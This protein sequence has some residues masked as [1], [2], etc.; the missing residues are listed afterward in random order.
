VAEA[1][2]PAKLWHTRERSGISLDREQRWWHDGEPVEHP[3]IIEAFNKGLKV[4]DDG[5]YKLEFGDDWCFVEVQGAAYR[6]LVLDEAEGDRLSI[7]L[8]D[9]TAEWLDVGS[10]V[11]DADGVLTAAVKGGRARARFSREAQFAL[12]ERVVSEGGAALVRIGGRSVPL[13]QAAWPLDT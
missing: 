9:R 5:R 8:S 13:P 2:P 10:L 6:V 11:L 4:Q 7:R 1:P 12:G 3:R